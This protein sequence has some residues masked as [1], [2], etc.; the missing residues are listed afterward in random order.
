MI[1]Y[2]G[3]RAFV[4]YLHVI[5]PVLEYHPDFIFSVRGLDWDT[6]TRVIGHD[7]IYKPIGREGEGNVYPELES[8]QPHH[9]RI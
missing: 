4:V 8:P 3:F 5:V 2:P 7:S 6:F 1:R 9:V